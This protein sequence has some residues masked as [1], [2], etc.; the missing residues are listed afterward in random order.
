M[1]RKRLLQASFF[2]VL[3]TNALLLGE[4][5]TPD[6]PLY[7]KWD[8]E[9]EKL[10]QVER[11]GGQYFA[12]ITAMAVDD[13]ETVFVADRKTVKIF[14]FNK[15]GEFI[16]SFGKEG[17]GPG[18]IKRFDHMFL[19]NDR[20]LIPDKGTNKVHY[21]SKE[22]KYLKSTPLPNRLTPRVFIDE[23]RL[24]SAPYIDHRDPKGK[25]EVILY[26]IESKT[27]TQLFDYMTFR[28]G[29]VRKTTKTS[30]STF[31]YSHSAITPILILAYRD[32][33]IYY[34]MNHRYR[35]TIRDLDQGELSTFGLKRERKKVPHRFKDE[36]MAGINFPENIKE[37]IKKGFPDHFTYFESIQV[38]SDGLIYVFATDYSALNRRTIDIFSPTGKYIYAAG[39]KSGP[40]TTIRRVHFHK[41]KL[42][43][44]VED[45]EGEVTLI[46]YR[47]RVPR[48]RREMLARAGSRRSSRFWRGR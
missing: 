43:L 6:Q 22:G 33:K 9:P 44:V 45:E 3:I 27:K 19:V 26:D 25:G 34:G 4:V 36:I 42:C 15:E 7:G 31:S 23:N 8:F 46:K 48:Q 2:V 10:W 35:I 38:T 13:K 40:G 5:M 12:D 47:I 41:D 17:E 39:I 30:S 11:G 28:K 16:S 32:N 21:F 14:I 37:Q 18:E 29:V 24:L 20:L 1:K